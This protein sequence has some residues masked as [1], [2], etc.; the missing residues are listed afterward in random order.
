M[1]I[2][3]IPK[4]MAWCKESICLGYKGE[5]NLVKLSD[6][7]EACELFQTGKSQEARVTLLNEQRFALAKDEQTTFIDLEGN[8]KR[9]AVNWTEIPSD[10]GVRPSVLNLDDIQVPGDQTEEP[11]LLSR[12]WNWP[13]PSLFRWLNPE[14]FISLPAPSFG[15]WIWSPFR[16]N[17]PTFNRQAIRIGHHVIRHRRRTPRRKKQNEFKYPDSLLLRS[18][19]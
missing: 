14:P 16:S 10:M 5:Y 19:H 11:R 7:N 3:D 17:T 8:M 12:T 18:L 4:S 13:N 9:Y 6:K 15:S 1:T 2:P